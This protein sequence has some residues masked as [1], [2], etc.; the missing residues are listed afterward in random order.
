VAEVYKDPRGQVERQNNFINE[1]EL[2]KNKLQNQKHEGLFPNS[3]DRN[4]IRSFGKQ[5]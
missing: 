5:P 1:R 2:Q 3:S 4:K